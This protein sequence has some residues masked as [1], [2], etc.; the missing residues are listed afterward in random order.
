MITS[1]ALVPYME[2]GSFESR[3]ESITLEELQASA[4]TT[5]NKEWLGREWKKSLKELDT[6][7]LAQVNVPDEFQEVLVEAWMT[8]LK[9]EKSF[10]LSDTEFSLP[11]IRAF[12]EVLKTN[13]DLENLLLCNHTID[14]SALVVLA[15]AIGENSSLQ[16]LH[17]HNNSL[18]DEGALALVGALKENLG[19]KKIELRNNMI[20]DEGASAFAE[21]F[22]VTKMAM[23]Q[24][25]D[26]LQIFIILSSLE[27]LDLSYNDIGDAGAI[28]LS[29]ALVHKEAS[30][31]PNPRK[32]IMPP[33]PK[34][35]LTPPTGFGSSGMF[36]GGM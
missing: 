20:G 2:A 24:N 30:S 8:A 26:S 34:R 11:S 5:D 17:F 28:S 27:V 1:N 6:S 23:S 18:G 35:S 32:S 15:E 3:E 7:D 31:L 19:I 25:S 13:E 10:L 14:D 16:E 9:G 36:G 33:V 29:K 12:S 4:V 22:D 21:V